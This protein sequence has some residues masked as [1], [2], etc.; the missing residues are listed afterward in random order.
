MDV[1]RDTLSYYTTSLSNHIDPIRKYVPQGQLRET[2]NGTIDLLLNLSLIY[3]TKDSCPW[4]FLRS[5][6]TAIIIRKVKSYPL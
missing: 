4:K 5:W 1:L 2:G 6:T 3:L